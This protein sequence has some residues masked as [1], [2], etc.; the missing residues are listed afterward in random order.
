M[1]P[2][3]RIVLCSIAFGSFVSLVPGCDS[4]EI[5]IQVQ[6]VVP[7]NPETCMPDSSDQAPSVSRGTL[8]LI[9]TNHY[10][11]NL[12]VINIM[13]NPLVVNDLDEE[14]GYVNTTDVNLTEAIV[15]YVDVDD[16]GLGFD[17]EIKVPLSGLLPSGSA[18]PVG[19]QITVITE[20]MADNLRDSGLF[21]GR[22]AAGRVAPVKTNFTLSVNV[23]LVGKTLDGKRV[24]SNEISF[25]IDLCTGCR[26]S[27]Q[28]RADT[29]DM[30]S[31]DDVEGLAACPGIIGRDSFYATC[32]LCRQI[33]V[34]ERFAPL[35][36]D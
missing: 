7:I 27:T 3:V 36:L 32:A 8:D 2:F 22:N 10:D 11:L 15:R 19:Q 26:V 20:A 31:E 24:E 4:E 34:D 16:I 25:P 28:G 18:N 1:S 21:D 29:C 12:A 17:P 30:V 33:V 35:C 23:K 6:K 9:L 13:Q 14:D 5:Y